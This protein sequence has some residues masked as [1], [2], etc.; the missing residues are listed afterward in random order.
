MK[1]LVFVLLIL[2]AFS[3]CSM[4]QVVMGTVVDEQGQPAEFASVSLCRADSSVITMCVTDINGKF[5]TADTRISPALIK[6]SMLGYETKW[7]KYPLHESIRIEPSAVS[8]SEVVVRGRKRLVKMTDSGLVYDMS[9]NVRAQSENLLQALRY[10]PLLE[11]DAQG[12][13]TVKG[14]SKYTLYLNGR[15]YEIAQANPTQVLQSIPASKIKRIEV[16]TEADSR[17]MNMDGTPIVNIVTAKKSLEG[18]YTNIYGGGNTQPQANGGLSVMA[19][20][21]KVDM[22]VSY[23]YSLNGQRDQP[24]TQCYK[25]DDKEINI[26]GK[27]DGDWHNHT[28]RLMTKWHIDTLNVVYADAHARIKRTNF[29]ESWNQKVA[30]NDGTQTVSQ[31]DNI[32]DNTS[33]TVEANVI[34]RNYFRNKPSRVHY[35]LGYRYTYN[36]DKRHFSQHLYDADGEESVSSVKTDGGLHDHT[37]NFSSIVPL[38]PLHLMRIG[39]S[40]VLRVG[41]TSSTS[42]EDINY[43]ENLLTPYFMYVGN[44]SPFVFTVSG[45]GE[46]DYLTMKL[47]YQSER[48]FHRNNFYVIPSAKVDWRLSDVS[49]LG[50]E[51]SM[52]VQRPLI[53]QLNPFYS[54]Q[55][56]YTA[57]CGNPNLKAE[58][59]HNVV[60]NYSLFGSNI[61]AMGDVTY[62]HTADAVLYYKQGEAAYG[63][64]LSTYDN[65]GS[66]N[67]VVGSLYVNWNP[68]SFLA[69]T[70]YLKGGYYG[71]RAPEVGLKQNAWNYYA[72][73]NANI[74]LPKS[75]TMG[76]LFRQYKN[77]PAPWSTEN[78]M[79]GYSL[80]IDKSWLKGALTAG[81]EVNSPFRKYMK[82]NVTTSKSDF[83]ARQTNYITARSFGVRM[84]YTFS[85][86]KANRLKRD[87]TLQSK[88]QNTGVN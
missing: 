55:N 23:D 60:L 35:A 73:A 39:V 58:K 68:V 34:Y 85:S 75:L 25:Y 17:F 38:A 51:Y 72:Q 28:V 61:V 32:N 15:P 62:T 83:W 19:T 14:N 6:V 74:Y 56:N 2:V 63:R 18:I 10:V 54:V 9:N 13:L 16:I 70:M 11:V 36:P 29:T 27:G 82:L 12:V 59:R 64:M 50:I 71:L 46:Y 76:L 41:S 48:N 87:K 31:F 3:I 44:V 49:K 45:R 84:S 86:G 53:E 47:P 7:A 77:V 8:L 79:N 43:T 22:S 20:K 65:L 78:S 66:V 1:R 67:S 81:I 24:I 42:L 57:S 21:G 52:N 80:R 69:L 26:D 30:Q 33:G 40:D 5:E 88:D 37:F 4:G